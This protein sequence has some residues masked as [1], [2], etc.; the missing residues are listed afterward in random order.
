[1]IK[2][3]LSAAAL[4][5]AGLAAVVPAAEAGT[6][7]MYTCNPPGFNI[8]NPTVGPWQFYNAGNAA[9]QAQNTCSGGGF[10]GTSNNGNEMTIQSESGWQ[11][12]TPPGIG[13]VRVRNWSRT[14]L[15]VAPGYQLYVTSSGAFANGNISP[16]IASPN[17]GGDDT[18]G[19][20][21]EPGTYDPPA[22]SHRLSIVCTPS[23]NG[24]PCRMADHVTLAIKGTV[25]ELS[26]STLPTASM[27]GGSLLTSDSVTGTA[28]LAYAAKDDHS[29][30]QR[31]EAILGDT[32]VGVDDF[33][34]DLT[35]PVAQQ[36]GQCTYTGFAACPQ[37]QTR[38]LQID[39]GRAPD[40]THRLTL[41]VTDA[42]GNRTDVPGP[43]F[44]VTNGTKGLKPGEANGTNASRLA[45]LTGRFAKTKRKALRMRYR[46]QPT[47][48]GRLVNERNQPITGALVAIRTRRKQAGARPVQV[49]TVRTD[50]DGRFSYKLSGG[51]SRTVTFQYYAFGGDAK[52]AEERSI[53]TVVRASI[54]ARPT[55][56]RVRVNGLLRVE[57]KL[58]LLPRSGVALTIQARDGRVWRTIGE[59]KTKG[60]G[61][62]SWPYR[63]KGG[64]AGRTFQFRV[65]VDS[66]IYPFAP[67][68]SKAFR[69]RVR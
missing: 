3:S 49:A 51:P 42:A 9:G 30:I 59:T 69:I 2:R 12:D 52:P 36:G 19:V 10:F 44:T 33:S 67:S 34:R 11:L 50:G 41:R 13:I 32:V 15:D 61:R 22:T 47:V 57:G 7:K 14:A 28:T 48:R 62:F 26:E 68:V 23:G 60:A 31:V 58:N 1:M 8:A 66:P 16:G 25:A 18:K 45:K 24:N 35:A 54:S 43:T 29:G 55:P 53:R 39:T 46:S 5:V 21:Y 63:F 17:A 27:T 65:R 56:R 64:A 40:G 38:D 20:G 4:T 37:T 6:Y